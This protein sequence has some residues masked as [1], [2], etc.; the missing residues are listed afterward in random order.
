MSSSGDQGD[1]TKS[2]VHTQLSS[3]DFYAKV[4]KAVEESAAAGK[5]VDEASIIEAIQSQGLLNDVMLDLGVSSSASSG[6][7]GGY[8]KVRALNLQ[9]LKGAAF[10]DYVEGGDGAYFELHVHFAGGRLHR[11]TSKATPCAVEPA[12]EETFTLELQPAGSSERLIDLYSLLQIDCPIH[13]VLL[14]VTDQGGSP[15]RELVAT[16]SLEWRSVLNRGT[17]S[18][19]IELQAS[20]A[21]AKLQHSVGV[22]NIKLDLLPSAG[23]GELLTLSEIKR[24]IETSQRERAT[25]QKEFFQYAKLWWRQ[26]SEIEPKFRQRLV[27]IFAENERAE[28][29]P[30][31]SF[32]Q[33]LRAGRLTGISTPRHAARFVGLIPFAREDSVGGGRQETWHSLHTFLALGKGDCEDHALLLCSLLLGFGMDAYVCVGTATDSPDAGYGGGNSGGGGGGHG[34]SFAGGAV[35]GVVLHDHV[36]VVTV[37]G[38]E[39]VGDASGA[40]GGGRRGTFWESL[41]GNRY[42]AARERERER[43]RERESE[44]ARERESERARE[45]ER[46]RERGGRERARE[47]ERER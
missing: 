8:S 31:C 14:K 19:A 11:F 25:S 9:I 44:R 1:L 34:V 41:K 33:R 45:R 3:Q 43:A 40:A 27:K 7:A 15:N 2:L 26:Y 37:S 28:H 47:R 21:E 6:N 30:V 36:W 23:T 38:A 18:R 35:D 32:V 10:T 4:R 39:T 42:R 24:T 46:E 16:H 12:F 20:G 5:P 29:R 17:L 22:L 13:F